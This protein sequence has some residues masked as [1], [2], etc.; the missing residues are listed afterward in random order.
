M[1]LDDLKETD[2]WT[3]YEQARN[4]CRMINMYADTNKNYRFFNGN[5]WEGLKVKGIEPVQ[6]N[7]IKPIVKYKVGIINSNLWKPHFSSENFENKEFRKRAEQI[8]EMLNKKAAKIWEKDGLDLKVRKVSKDSSIN[9]EGVMYV[10][11]DNKEQC[12]LNEILTKNDIY[13]GN[14]NDSDIQRQPYIL[15]KQRIPVIEAQKMAEND[16][17]SKEKLQFIVGD[18]DNFEQAGEQSRLEKD[19]MCTI[20]TKMYKENGTVHF[21]KATR[22]V[23]LKSDKDSGLTRY[24]VAH[25]PWDEKMG[26][27]RG[28]GEVRYH[29]PNQIEVNKTI[30]RRLITV[31]QTAYPQKI[32]NTD[33]ITNPDAVDTVGGTIRTKNGNSIDDVKK[34]FGI[35]NPAQMSPDVEKL[36]NDLISITRELAGA[37]DIATGQVNPESASG[38]AILAVQQASQ[39]PLVDQ[40]NSLKD[41]IEDLVRIWLD[42]F[43][44]YS[45]E[46]MMLEEEVTSENGKQVIQPIKISQDELKE[47][48]ATVKVD[49]TPKGAFDKYAQEV[50]LENLLKAGYFNIQRLP[51]LK[52]YVKL[53]DDD[54]VMPKNKIE[55]A[56][57]LMEEEQQ[58]IAQIN[59]QA[60]IMKQ[61]ANQF[62][63]NDPDAQAQQIAEANET[64]KMS[65]VGNEV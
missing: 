27:A 40:L 5:Q 37:G 55:D 2:I 43:I 22:F 13:Y 8:C 53:L 34:V 59:A 10:D 30:M 64:L 9:D 62:I 4:Y 44:T 49:V 29:I 25:F 54:S 32:V 38:R 50:S 28:E 36:Q 47:L 42:M 51:E 31:K 19:N 35:I 15:I 18:T 60:Q 14:E 58:K 23:E 16:G 46:G 61:R 1:D 6:L 21:S 3:L 57:V 45:R 56:I 12:P 52:I 48:R 65:A 24:P 33:K 41:F 63:N 17:V 11:Y 39:Q 26:S 20:I 7:F